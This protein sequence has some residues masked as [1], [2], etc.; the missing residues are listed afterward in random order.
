MAVDTSKAVESALSGGLG[1]N[2]GGGDIT[3]DL[4]AHSSAKGGT[5]MIGGF[6]FG[7][8]NPTSNSTLYIMITVALVVLFFLWKM[9]VFK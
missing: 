7:S 2:S 8:Y 9:G 3:P 5:N 4:S 1:I 6:T